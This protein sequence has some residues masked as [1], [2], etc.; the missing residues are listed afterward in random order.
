MSRSG[1]SKLCI[2]C[3]V[4]LSLAWVAG[5]SGQPLQP[6]DLSGSEGGWVHPRGTGFQPVPGSPSPVRQD[7]GHPF[8]P[9]R[10][11]AWRIGDLSNPNLKPWVKELMKK[12]TD[13]IDAGKIAFQPSAACV[14]SGVP[15]M[16][17]FPNPLLILQT[18]KKVLM[19]KEGGMEVR[20]I[21]LDVPHSAKPKPSWYGESVGHYD[22]DTLVVDTIGQNAKTVVDGYRTP[23][24]E[25]LHVVERFHLINEGKALEVNITVDDPDTFNQPWSTFLRYNRGNQNQTF[26]EDICAENNG[27]IFDYHMPVAEKSDF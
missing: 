24:S 25:K 26:A 16:F 1:L 7:P 4:V 12:D 15:N 27:I 23:H 10:G 6:P 18:P 19:I 9:G 8:T 20:H 22:G 11:T 3:S 21:Y 13:E 2:V 14:P 5:A 17:S